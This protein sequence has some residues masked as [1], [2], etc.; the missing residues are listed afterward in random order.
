M[1]MMSSTS[2]TSTSGVTLMSDF[3]P[4]TPLT[5]ISASRPVSPP[6]GLRDEPHVHEADLATRLEHLDHRPVG[7]TAIALDCDLAVGSPFVDG[8]DLAH[9]LL[10]AHH[11]RPDV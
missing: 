11:Q 10:L 9:Q 4:F 3:A 2:T 6:L 8:L 5:C 7:D 1:K